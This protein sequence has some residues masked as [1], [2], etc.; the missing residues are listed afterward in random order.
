MNFKHI[1]LSK[2]GHAK[3]ATQFYLYSILKK[4]KLE[5]NTN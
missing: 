5:E 3:E 4:A 1:M 2:R